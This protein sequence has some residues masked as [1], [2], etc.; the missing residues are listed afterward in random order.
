MQN[1]EL[2]WAAGFFDGE[3][4]TSLKAKRKPCLSVTQKYPECLQRF[5]AALG[6]GKIYGP[7]EQKGNQIYIFSIQNAR[8]VDTALSLLWPFLSSIKRAQAEKAG[9]QVGTIRTPKIGR[10]RKEAQ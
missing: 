7:I 6:L 4:C 9:F 10:P 1:T 5:Q 8:G 3:G 2:A